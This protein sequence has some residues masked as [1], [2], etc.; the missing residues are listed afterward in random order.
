M[1][2]APWTFADWFYRIAFWILLILIVVILVCWYLHVRYYKRLLA[3][4]RRT[5]PLEKW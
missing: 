1:V 2:P 3:Q 4:Y 5:L